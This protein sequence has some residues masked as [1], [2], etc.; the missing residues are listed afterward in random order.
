[1][2]DVALIIGAGDATGSS[3]AQRIAREGL[4]TCVTRRKVE[5]LAP[6]QAAIEAA[7]GRCHAFG[8]EKTR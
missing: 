7:G 5:Q 3:I 8:S 1:M 6:L 2:H 4:T